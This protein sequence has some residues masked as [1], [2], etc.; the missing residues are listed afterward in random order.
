MKPYRTRLYPQ[1]PFSLWL[2]GLL[3]LLKAVFWLFANP[4]IV[5]PIL[6][7][8]HVLTTLPLLF[9]WR[10]VWNRKDWAVKAAMALVFLDLLFFVGLYPG[11]IAVPFD[12]S[13]L[14][15][16][17]GQG[18]YGF[19]FIF[20][21]LLITLCSTMIGYGINILILLTGAVALRYQNVS[22]A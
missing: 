7:I 5:E 14:E 10:A 15:I 21:N 16:H 11:S 13:P 19:F 2:L 9:L 4:L 18:L 12:I 1:Y 6:G 22:A 17:P 8:K 3:L 20:L